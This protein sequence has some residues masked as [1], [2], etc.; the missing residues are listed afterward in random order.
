MGKDKQA[1]GV[2]RLSAA[3]IK[4]MFDDLDDKTN[5]RLKEAV[6][7]LTALVTKN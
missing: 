4:P 1:D 3:D 6:I 5:P 2:L 7:H